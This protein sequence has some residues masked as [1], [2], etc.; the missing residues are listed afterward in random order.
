MAARVNSRFVVILA[1]VLSVAFAL[2]A[3]VGMRMIHKSGEQLAAM[4][5]EQMK[6]GKYK[7]AALL[8]SKAVNKDQ[9]NPEML[10]KWIS[11]LEKMSPE[12]VQEY[13]D[14][15]FRSYVTATRALAEVLKTDLTAHRRFFDEQYRRIVLF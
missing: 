4:G 11:A 14:V 6:A 7:E 9:Q 13:Q 1:V 3:V 12:Q 15:Y 5:D 8:Y 10:R 2:V